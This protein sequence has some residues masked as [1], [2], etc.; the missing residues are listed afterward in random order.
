MPYVANQHNKEPCM[1][2]VELI[3]CI[4]QINR[5]AK[6]EFLQSFS[7][8]ELAQYLEHLME[9]DLNELALCA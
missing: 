3:E 8:E 4:T 1:S 2:K 6:A 9:L 7:E 5:S